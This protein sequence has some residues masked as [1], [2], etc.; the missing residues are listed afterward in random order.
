MFRPKLATMGYRKIEDQVKLAALRLWD[1]DL[2][3]LP[4]I[5]GVVDFSEST[6]WRAHKLWKD[7]GQPSKPPSN[8]RGR[9]RHL[10][11]D[12]LTYLLTLIRYR[13]QFFLD[14][15]QDLLCSNRFISV[16]FTTIHRELERRHFSTKVLRRI[17]SERS[18]IRRARF[19][20]RMGGYTPDQLMMTDETSKDD[21]TT[22]RRRGRSL[23]GQRAEAHD[24]FVRGVRYSLLPL[25]TLDGIVAAI[26][27]EGSV[28]RR[29]FLRFLE[30]HVM[31]LTS[32]FPGPRSVLIM[33]NARI[34]HGEDVEDLCSKYGVRLEYLPPYSPDLNP[35]EEAFSKIKSHLRRYGCPSAYDLLVSTDIITP[36]D[37]AGY[38]QHAG[39]T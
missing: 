30:K 20:T 4:T 36:D 24:V 39:Y 23:E 27:V 2:L 32:P 31:P 19:I 17:A 1:A 21:R 13:P 18:P 26:V 22:M 33:D 34:H 15:L 29:V 7:T 11:R 14:E 28:T 5:L 6:F 12:D 37:A 3:P 10:H 16:H 35:I 9:P 8:Q 38:F 25:L